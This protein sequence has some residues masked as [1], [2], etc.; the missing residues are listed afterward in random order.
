ML[1]NFSQIGFPKFPDGVI[2]VFLQGQIGSASEE[3]LLG[4]IFDYLIKFAFNIDLNDIKTY[5]RIFGV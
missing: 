1:Y 2:L 3:T 4:I 5:F